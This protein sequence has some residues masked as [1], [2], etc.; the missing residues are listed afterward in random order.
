M[1][2][3]GLSN[4]AMLAFAQNLHSVVNSFSKLKS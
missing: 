4:T 1:N 3:M 2:G